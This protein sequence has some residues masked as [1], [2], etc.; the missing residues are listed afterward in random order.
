MFLKISQEIGVIRNYAELM[1]PF[2]G[3]Y[4][5]FS[6]IRNKTNTSQMFFSTLYSSF[7]IF[8]LK[9]IKKK[10]LNDKI[11]SSINKIS[12]PENNIFFEIETCAGWNK[13]CYYLGYNCKEIIKKNSWVQIISNDHA[14]DLNKKIDLLYLYNT[15]DHLN[16]PLVI[17]ENLMG[18]IRNIFIEF[19]NLSGGAQHS[20]FLTPESIN[21]ISKKLN[22]K[23]K[24]IWN[25]NQYLLSKVE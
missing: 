6:Y 13:H 20:F 11:K 4:P 1:C 9:I 7:V 17:L 24:K 22:F 3:M 8:L 23:I 10:N 5:V 2:M 14:N 12:L 25:N 18:K 15:L 21:F 16:K 19:H